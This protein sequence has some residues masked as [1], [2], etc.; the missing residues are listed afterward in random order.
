[1][2][3]A[4]LPAE[5]LA[6]VLRDLAQVNGVTRAA[7]PT[8]R[9]LATATRPGDRFTLLDVGAGHGDMLRRIARWA[10]RTGR[11]ATLAG[12]D[13]N[14]HAAAIARRATDPALGITWHTG[15]AAAVVAAAPAPP[16]VIISSLVAHHMADDEL[17]AFLRWMEHTARLG[18][19]V[20]DLH[21]H[22]VAWHGYRLLA[23]AMRWDPI[24]RHDGALS[25]RRAFVRD[26]WERLLQAAGVPREAVTVRWHLPFRLCVGRRR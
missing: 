7:P 14:P 19:F 25:V 8:L 12:V 18:W 6:A 3:D 16:D 22:P 10:R 11:H 21:R 24:V 20:N 5:R 4:T 1:M 13:Q 2:D 17:V 23:A 26:D 9:W 15:E